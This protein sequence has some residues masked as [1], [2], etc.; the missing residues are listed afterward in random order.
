MQAA[1]AAIVSPA[2][3]VFDPTRE[4]S[5]ETVVLLWLP[6]S[7][8]LRWSLSFFVNGVPCSWAEKSEWRKRLGLPGPPRIIHNFGPTRSAR[9]QVRIDRGVG[10]F[11]SV[12]VGERL[13]FRRFSEPFTEK[14]V[15]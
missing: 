12:G 14:R 10:I 9:A 13:F 4:Y 5:A 2:R 6:P 8:T 15:S 7:D 3:S 11:H 1:I